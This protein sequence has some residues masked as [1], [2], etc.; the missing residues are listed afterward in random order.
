MQLLKCFWI[1]QNFL[2]VCSSW[3]IQFLDCLQLL[4]YTVSGLSAAPGLSKFFDCSQLRNFLKLL[5]CLMS[6]ASGLSA[7]LTLSETFRFL[8]RSSF[9]CSCSSISPAGCVGLFYLNS[10]RPEMIF[11][12]QRIVNPC[13]AAGK[14]NNFI[15]ALQL[16]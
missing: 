11:S 15:F 14:R 16:Q 2:I 12:R 10:F 6:E 7:A 9:S 1:V 5:D 4:D 3:I 8:F 13:W